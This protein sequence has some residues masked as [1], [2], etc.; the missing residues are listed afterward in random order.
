[1]GD[2]SF[3]LTSWTGDSGGDRRPQKGRSRWH[4]EGP[5]LGGDGVV[6]SGTPDTD[7]QPPSLGFTR[8]SSLSIEG[9]TPSPL[10]QE[11]G[12]KGFLT[13]VPFRDLGVSP[14]GPGRT[15]LRT[16]NEMSG[17]DLVWLVRQT[18]TGFRESKKTKKMN[19]MRRDHL[20]DGRVRG[21]CT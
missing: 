18:V 4:P 14:K 21:E 5:G 1:M 12:G 9:T 10:G 7:Y 15:R 11:V 2:M 16:E 17:E 20:K 8:C 3:P 13:R 19:F 6:E